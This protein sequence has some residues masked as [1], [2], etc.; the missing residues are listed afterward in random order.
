MLTI[1][2][3]PRSTIWA[4][5]ARLQRHTPSTL[6]SH[7]AR[8][9][10]SGTSSAGRWKH[11]PALLARMS[12]GPSSEVTVASMAPTLSVSVTSALTA[13]APSPAATSPERSWSRA[14]MATRAPASPRAR[15]NASPSPRLPPVTT[16]TLPSSR[17]E[18]RTAIAVDYSRGPRLGSPDS[19]LPSGTG[20]PVS[21]DQK[22]ADRYD[23][24]ILGGGLAGLCVGHQIKQARPDTS[25]FIA[26]KRQGPAREAAH[27]VGESTQEISCH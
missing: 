14:A 2:P 13:S 20:E 25:I 5:T 23:V 6:T 26:E 1:T 16:A 3:L 21:N 4:P 7:T 24:A 12:T 22:P 10:S 15:A 11:T 27:K 17:K 8:H 19:H 9:S 18:S